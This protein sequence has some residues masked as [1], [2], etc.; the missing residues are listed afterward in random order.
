MYLDLYL[1]LHSYFDLY[2]D[3]DLGLYIYLYLKLNRVLQPPM[4]LFWYL[5]LDLFIEAMHLLKVN[6]NLTG[7][8]QRIYDEHVF[9]LFPTLSVTTHHQ[10]ITNKISS[11]CAQQCRLNILS[12]NY[13]SVCDGASH[14]VV[15]RV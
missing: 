15:T 13:F 11:S 12:S 10:D 1:D 7:S 9:R 3:L 6:S 14:F 2:Q 4:Y 5:D 8:R